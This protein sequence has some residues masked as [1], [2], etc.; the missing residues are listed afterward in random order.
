[1][2]RGMHGVKSGVYPTRFQDLRN[3][4]QK[5]TQIWDTKP[6]FL[7]LCA[8]REVVR[9]NVREIVFLRIILSTSKDQP[10]L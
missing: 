2:F 3:M 8:G 1:M 6:F 5:F 7:R 10:F 4:K 9:S